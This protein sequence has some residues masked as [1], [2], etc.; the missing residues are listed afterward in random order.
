MSLALALAY[1]PWSPNRELHSAFS[2]TRREMVLKLG[3]KVAE[4]AGIAPAI[5]RLTTCCCSL[6]SYNSVVRKARLAL[7]LWYTRFTG[8]AIR[9][10]RNL[11]E[12]VGMFLIARSNRLSALRYTRMNDLR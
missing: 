5:F 4:L 7:A 6:L 8:E 9:C 12:M 2:F 11:R 10:Y 3:A 1:E